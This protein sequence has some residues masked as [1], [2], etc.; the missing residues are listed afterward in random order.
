MTATT[1]ESRPFDAAA[2]AA[3]LERTARNSGLV[4]NAETLPGAAQTLAETVELS[5]TGLLSYID[6]PPFRIAGGEVVD[7]LVEEHVA[8]LLTAHTKPIASKPTQATRQAASPVIPPMKS[9]EPDWSRGRQD[10]F[11]QMVRATAAHE[12]AKIAKECE[13]WLNPFLKKNWNRTNQTIMMN[14]NPAL[15]MKHKAAAGL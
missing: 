5:P 13:S 9:S 11:A 8:A 3:W 12:D 4:F 10:T 15:A 2:A 7:V 14:R 1:Q 6:A